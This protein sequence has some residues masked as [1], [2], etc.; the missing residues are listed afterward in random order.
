MKVYKLLVLVLLAA[1]LLALVGQLPHK[2]LNQR[3]PHLPLKRLHPPKPH[4]LLKCLRLLKPQH[5]LKRQPSLLNC[6][7]RTMQMALKQMSSNR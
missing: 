6:A 1:L 3:K 5:P 7:L 2:R 4:P